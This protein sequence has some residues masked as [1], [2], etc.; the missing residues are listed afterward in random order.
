MAASGPSVLRASLP[1]WWR[2]C[3]IGAPFSRRL[4]RRPASVATSF[5]VCWLPNCQRERNAPV[6]KDQ[7]VDFV[8]R[9]RNQPVASASAHGLCMP[10][11]HRSKHLHTSNRSDREPR[12]SRAGEK[13]CRLVV[14]ASSVC[15]E[16]RHVFRA[17]RARECFRRAPLNV[18][19]IASLPCGPPI[20]RGGGSALV[21]HGLWG[22][23]LCRVRRQ[24]SLLHVACVCACDV[25]SGKCAR[26]HGRRRCAGSPRLVPRQVQRARRLV[27]RQLAAR[28]RHLLRH[29]SVA[30]R[31]GGWITASLGAVAAH[32]L[33]ANRLV[34]SQRPDPQVSTSTHLSTHSP[35]DAQ[36][37]LRIACGSMP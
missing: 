30:V 9:R 17:L 24:T 35:V 10:D 34:S 3:L 19:C 8:R 18:V 27:W 32:E 37:A 29:R 36:V 12:S 11:D 6:I 14:L 7:V 13:I 4:A 16:A 23:G 5:H 25:D 2:A 20:A 26:G 33:S 1:P 22:R 28:P 15:V 21:A 31:A